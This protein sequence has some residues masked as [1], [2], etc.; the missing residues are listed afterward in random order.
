LRT[1]HGAPA[2]RTSAAS[3]SDSSTL[4]V[5]TRTGRPEA[6]SDRPDD[7]RE[8]V[9]R[10]RGRFAAE[11]GRSCRSF[12]AVIGSIVPAS[13]RE[14]LPFCPV[15]RGGDPG[16]RAGGKVVRNRGPKVLEV[17]TCPGFRVFK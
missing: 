15:T 6:W 1:R 17:D 3:L 9:S 12:S 7:R 16:H 13:P 4:A 2:P 8:V 10:L 5:P 14:G 11:P